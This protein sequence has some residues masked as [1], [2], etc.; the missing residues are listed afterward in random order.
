MNTNSNLTVAT[1]NTIVSIPRNDEVAE[2]E[3]YKP[4]ALKRI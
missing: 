2:H 1:E 3:Q 4:G